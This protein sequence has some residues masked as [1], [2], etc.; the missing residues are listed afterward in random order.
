MLHQ[1]PAQSRLTDLEYRKKILWLWSRVRFARARTIYHNQT[2]IRSFEKAV[3]RFSRV[4]EFGYR[5]GEQQ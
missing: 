3:L 1:G 5:E 4:L 2:R